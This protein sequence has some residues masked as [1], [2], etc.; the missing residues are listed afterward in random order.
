MNKVLVITGAT[1]VGKSSLAIDIAQRFNGELINADSQQV[2]QELNIATAKV[3]QTMRQRVPHHGLDVV[4]YDQTYSVKA[5]QDMARWVIQACHLNQ[6]LPILVG[7]SGLYLKACLYDYSFETD[8]P[9]DQNFDTQSNE[10]LYQQLQTLDPT[11]SQTIHPNN[12]KRVI[13]ALSLA[14]SGDSKTQREA[15]QNKALI[16]DVLFVVLD[17]QR[18]HL[19]QRIEQRVDEMFEAGL[20]EEV[21]HYFSQ[22]HTWSYQSF[23]AIGYKEWQAYFEHGISEEEVKQKIIQATRQY[24]KRQYTWF[25]HQFEGVWFNLDEEPIEQLL[26]IIQLWLNKEKL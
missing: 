16:Y 7:G 14:L 17:R 3:D 26:N 21:I 19:H 18:S 13:R 6:R 10:V 25:R 12:R 1:A 11:A 24:A 4:H 20:K 15:K 2:Y 23:Q 5:Y 8:R 9:I 22:P